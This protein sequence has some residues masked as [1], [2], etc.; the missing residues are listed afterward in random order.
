M[1]KMLT[2]KEIKEILNNY[3][4][5]MKLIIHQ[6]GNARDYPVVSTDI[7]IRDYVYFSSCGLIENEPEENENVLQI[8][9]I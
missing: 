6:D 9:T 1:M 2:V 8:G 7:K 3:P 4:D 5:D